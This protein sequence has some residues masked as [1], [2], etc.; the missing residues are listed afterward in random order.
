MLVCHDMEELWKSSADLEHALKTGFDGNPAWV[1]SGPMREPY[2]SF[3]LMLKYPEGISFRPAVRK[4]GVPDHL[5]LIQV[6][7]LIDE[8]VDGRVPLTIS[9]FLHSR[10]LYEKGGYN[11]NE[12]ESPTRESVEASK[13][14]I[15]PVDFWSARGYFFDHKKST[16]VDENGADLNGKK[17]L[18]EI[19][20]LHVGVTRRVRGAILRWKI[21]WKARLA[22]VAGLF[23]SAVLWTLRV[24]LGRTIQSPIAFQ[25]YR[26]GISK[27]QMNLVEPD[28]IE[29]FGWKAS[30]RSVLLF[31]CVQL[32]VAF[33]IFLL[34]WE[35]T[36]AWDVFSNSVFTLS[37]A[38]FS[39]WIIDSVAVEVLRWGANRFLALQRRLLGGSK[40][41]KTAGFFH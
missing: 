28:F 33:T 3:F 38:I 9:A 30:K 23:A 11:F 18:D 13:S 34:E 1:K 19:T 39:L 32:V 8:A 24:V 15:R 20:D 31:A 16:F 37:Y 5:V 17:L 26:G 36:R 6:G 14:S 10:Y 29:V 12:D 21:N 2:P 41:R 25:L 35:T 22:A 4:D 40:I 7:Y 27:D